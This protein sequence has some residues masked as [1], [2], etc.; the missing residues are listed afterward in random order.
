VSKEKR[1][2]GSGF[3][4][5]KKIQKT[6]GECEK[7]KTENLKME[8]VWLSNAAKKKEKPPHCPKP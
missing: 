2:G 3:S 1:W 7:G 8:K 6:I 4:G 5:K